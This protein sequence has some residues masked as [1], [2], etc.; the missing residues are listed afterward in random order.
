M[1]VSCEMKSKFDQMYDYLV[2][3]SNQLSFLNTNHNMKNLCYQD[4]G[5]SSDV[6]VVIRNIVVDTMLHKIAMVPMSFP[7]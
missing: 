2:G 6:P 4:F 3:R 1:A 5:S 7:C